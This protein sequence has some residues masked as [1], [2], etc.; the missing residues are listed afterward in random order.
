MTIRSK[1]VACWAITGVLCVLAPHV[2]SGQAAADSP[3]SQAGPAVE[4]TAAQLF[5]YAEEAKAKGNFETAEAAFQAL[6]QDPDIELRTEARF[7]LALLYADRMDKPR[8]AAV[9]LRRILDDKPDAAGVRLELARIQAVMGNMREARRELRAV[10]ATGLPPQVEQM[11]RFYSKALTA[12][13]RLGGSL[14]VALAPS[15]NIN[16]ATSSD[17][18]GTII[19]DFTLSEDAQAKSGM[20]VSLRGQSYW[21]VPLSA[22]TDILL[23]A[24]GSGDLYKEKDFDDVTAS[25]QVGPQ[26]RWGADR[27]S[28][29]GAASWRWYG[30]KPYSTSVGVTGDWQHPLGKRTQLRLDGRVLFEDNRR[31]DLQDGE[32]YSASI[33]LDRAF[34]SRFG[35]GVQVHGMRDDAKDPGYSTTSGGVSLYAYREMGR[36]TA[37]ANVSY[38]RLEADRR[39]FLYPERR[40]DDNASASLSVTFR[41]LTFG[42]FAPMARVRYEKN[43]STIEIYE[44][45]RV[46]AEVGIVA[47]F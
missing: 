27:F 4:M 38:R 34:S 40:K 20:G 26:W 8:E 24:S 46:A 1:K 3:A 19:G 29:S 21:R 31:N 23:R 43:W 37:V 32:R 47:A 18:L 28:L 36:T 5:Q 7:R 12:Q 10:Q 35:G 41:G 2:A 9:L 25:V 16:R 44:F 22:K 17:T 11:V 30:L 6:T 39:L 15:T 14:Q 33:G 45:D 13:K 42:T